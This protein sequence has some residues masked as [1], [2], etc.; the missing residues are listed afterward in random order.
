MLTTNTSVT[1]TF[2]FFKHY[3]GTV[4]LQIM[5]QF[6]QRKA[7]MFCRR[8]P[9]NLNFYRTWKYGLCTGTS[10]LGKPSEAHSSKSRY[11][12]L[13]VSQRIR[14]DVFVNM[15][16][17]NRIAPVRKTWS[18]MPPT[19]ASI[20]EAMKSGLSSSVGCKVT[21]SN[22][23]VEELVSFVADVV[24]LPES[25]FEYKLRNDL[26]TECIRRIPD[27]DQKAMLYVA[28]VFFVMNMTSNRYLK[29]VFQEFERR[30]NTLS[31]TKE[32]ILQL[33]FFLSILRTSSLFLMHKV[34]E[35]ISEHA[36]Q[37]S[38]NEIGLVCHTFFVT[39]TAFRNFRTLE[40][41]SGLVL[42][43]VDKE[44]FRVG[45]LV[46]IM[47]T[48]RH[49]QFPGVRFYKDLGT[50]LCQKR[51]LQDATLSDL[52][53]LSFTYSS[54]RMVHRGL[55]DY[56][57]ALTKSKISSEKLNYVRMK[58]LG[59][60]FWSSMMMCADIPRDMLEKLLYIMRLDSQLP[61]RYPE[62]FVEGL[63]A[64]AVNRIYPDDLLDIVFSPKYLAFK[65]G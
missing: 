17:R 34:E 27:F 38:I 26:E 22:S 23:T 53:T 12:P 48:M 39:N 9:L 40:N 7:D 16:F 4:F 5:L 44:T 55:S 11:L 33:L 24:N 65:S 43:N 18:T 52:A 3:P 61:F 50:V 32:D 21:L 51:K 47:K 46:S 56:V 58:D 35:F 30:W 10:I 62:A 29:A 59:R 49:A 37:F 41:V 60:L 2:Y 19:S 36:S 31:I 64:L 20:F 13:A 25:K 57:N 8:I 42:N 15:N 63:V 28:D 45:L 1:K 6:V 54:L 14:Q